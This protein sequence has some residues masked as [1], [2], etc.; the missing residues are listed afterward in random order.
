[1]P[2]STRHLHWIAIATAVVV[3]VAHNVATQP[4]TLDDAYISFRYAENLVAGD[5]LVFNPGERVEGYTNFLWVMGV[6]ALNLVGL[7]SVEAAKLMGAVCTISL[8]AM[9]ASAEIT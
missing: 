3:L 9:M 6:A 5:G 2:L 7:G 4:W 1:M 8:M